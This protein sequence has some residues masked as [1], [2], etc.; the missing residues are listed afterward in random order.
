MA[1]RGSNV[2]YNTIPKLQEW[3]SIHYAVN[4]TRFVLLGPTSS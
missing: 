1:K 3:L 4:A 2:V